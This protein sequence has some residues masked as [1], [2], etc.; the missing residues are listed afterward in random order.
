VTQSFHFR[1]I[2][3]YTQEPVR[4]F[5]YIYIPWECDKLGLW[6]CIINFSP[7]TGFLWL[8]ELCECSPYCFFRCVFL[9]W[10]KVED[11]IR[12]MWIF[13]SRLL[14][15]RTW[16]ILRYS[17]EHQHFGNWK[18]FRPQERGW[19]IPAVLGRLERANINDQQ[20]RCTGSSY[21]DVGRAMI[22]VRYF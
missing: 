2:A 22:E 3:I 1:N 16:S 5:N 10:F 21:S 4:F 12:N 20:S 9:T 15:F 13:Y 18:Y 8:L 17:E 19:D 14:S 7:D 6:D 11:P